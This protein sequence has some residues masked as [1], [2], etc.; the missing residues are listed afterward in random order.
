MKNYT[1]TVPVERTISRI[2]QILAKAGAGSIHKEYREGK[3]TALSFSLQVSKERTVSIRLPADVG[4]VE[5]ILIDGIKRPHK[6]TLKRVT[7]QAA[8]TAWKLMQDWIEVQISMI[9]MHQVEALQ[10]FLPYIW[11]GSRTLYAA[12]KEG[13]FKLLPEKGGQK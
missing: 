6:E 9:E 7:D 11:D 13:G 10:V 3:A 4:A 8:R 1:S 5:R 2:E 12:F